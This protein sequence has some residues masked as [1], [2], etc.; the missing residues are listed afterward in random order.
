M[1]ALELQ[2]ANG[3]FKQLVSSISTFYS[4]EAVGQLHKIVGS[5]DVLGNPVKLFSTVSSGVSDMFYEPLLGFQITRPQ[6]FGINVVKG[7]GSLFKKTVFGLSDTLAKFTGSVGKGL[8]V[9]TMD[10]KFQVNRLRRNRPRH[11]ISGVTDGATNFARS[12]TSGVSGIFTKPIEGAKSEGVGGF[13]KGLGK[14]VVGVVAKPIV[15]VFDLASSVTEGIKNTTTVFDKE[16]ERVRLPRHIAADKIIRP[17]NLHE[18]SGLE[19]LQKLAKGKYRV[20]KYIAHLELNPT[21]EP[22]IQNAI[23]LLTNTKL[24]YFFKRNLDIEWIISAE[25]IHDDI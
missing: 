5:A 8:S 19:Y 3:P 2:H 11:A 7:T 20:E 9:A 12:I 14:G 13:F 17:Y 24:F 18:A 21:V 16:L 22:G 10:E 6:D 4:Q 15:G 25:G 1:N 23:L